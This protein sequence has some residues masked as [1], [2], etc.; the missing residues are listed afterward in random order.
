MCTRSLP[1]LDQEVG[2][3]LENKSSLI[4]FNGTDRMMILVEEHVL[5]RKSN[6]ETNPDILDQWEGQE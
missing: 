2:A 3:P 6:A 5:P 4:R 1:L